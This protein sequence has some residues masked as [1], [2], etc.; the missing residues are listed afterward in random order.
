M[1]SCSSN[2]RGKKVL[3]PKEKK[4][5]TNRKSELSGAWEKKRVRWEELRERVREKKRGK[6]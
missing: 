3:K 4:K 5:E 6:A 1:N 2:E